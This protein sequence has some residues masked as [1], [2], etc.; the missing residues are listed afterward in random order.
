MLSDW[1]KGVKW[2]RWSYHHASHLLF[3]ATTEYGRI[4]TYHG[5][6]YLV[7]KE[8]EVGKIP[9]YVSLSV[10]GIRRPTKHWG[11]YTFF[12]G[13]DTTKEAEYVMEMF[14]YPKLTDKAQ[15]KLKA[16]FAKYGD[17]VETD[18]SFINIL[19]ARERRLKDD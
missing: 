7:N 6:D 13:F 1:L 9:Y 16:I 4:Y 11:P 3:I 14:Q 2:T 12:N 17:W 5:Q 10:R 18:M 8:G 15:A 19:G